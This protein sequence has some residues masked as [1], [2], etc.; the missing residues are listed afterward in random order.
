[1]EATKKMS[2]EK[3]SE[4]NKLSKEEREKID[5]VVAEFAER[6]YNEKVRFVNGIREVIGSCGL[7]RDSIIGLLEM[8]FFNLL[9]NT[10]NWD[11]LK[12]ELKEKTGGKKN[13][14]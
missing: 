2:K 14:K 3:E 8:E 7:E 10:V 12:Q 9:L 13:G 11:V 5:K 4:I 6:Q 1:M